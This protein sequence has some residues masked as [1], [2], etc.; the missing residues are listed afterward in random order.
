MMF[1]PPALRQARQLLAR[2]E[3]AAPVPNASLAF[4]CSRSFPLGADVAQLIDREAQT[5]DLKKMVARLCLT[6]RLH[7]NLCSVA[8]SLAFLEGPPHFMRFV[9]GELYADTRDF[10]VMPGR[11]GPAYSEV[12]AKM[13]VFSAGMAEGHSERVMSRAHTFRNEYGNQNVDV[14]YSSGVAMGVYAIT[15][16][17]ED[18]VVYPQCNRFEI[19]HGQ[20][21]F[22]E[23]LRETVYSLMRA[24]GTNANRLIESQLMT[25]VDDMNTYLFKPGA[26][27]YM[28]HDPSIYNPWTFMQICLAHYDRCDPKVLNALLEEEQARAGYVCAGRTMDWRMSTALS[29]EEMRY[30]LSVWRV[31]WASVCTRLEDYFIPYLVGIAGN[32][33]GKASPRRIFTMLSDAVEGFGG[34]FDYYLGPHR[35]E[36]DEIRAG[37]AV[38]KSL[39]PANTR[40]ITPTFYPQDP[41]KLVAGGFSWHYLRDQYPTPLPELFDLDQANFESTVISNA[42]I[43]R[44]SVLAARIVEEGTRLV[45]LITHQYDL[46][47][48]FTPQLA[49]VHLYESYYRHFGQY[50]TYIDVNGLADFQP[51]PIFLGARPGMG[52]KMGEYGLGYYDIEPDPIQSPLLLKTEFKAWELSLLFGPLKVSDGVEWDPNEDAATGEEVVVQAQLV[53]GDD[54]NEEELDVDEVEDGELLGGDDDNEDHENQQMAF[55]P[56]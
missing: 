34:R 30:Q 5:T 42:M 10:F 8:R 20:V 38:L 55:W 14:Q 23:V 37:A 48:D 11:V 6:K 2:R 27:G 46:I 52:F 40:S 4:S 24:P 31:S 7:N 9:L 50:E 41:P 44:G 33:M 19:I 43:A 45:L 54:D 22:I 15:Y 25:L 36:R 53:G 13:I 26:I 29:L 17:D 56:A 1:H 28:R 12:K 35:L 51:A 16:E 49:F 18:S 47:R 21:K 32:D 3:S 39:L